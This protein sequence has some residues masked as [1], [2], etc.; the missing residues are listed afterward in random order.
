MPLP[1][2]TTASQNLPN[3]DWANFGSPHS[4]HKTLPASKNATQ[5]LPSH[6]WAN[7]GSHRPALSTVPRPSNDNATANDERTTRKF[8]FAEPPAA[9]K[10][11]TNNFGIQDKTPVSIF[12]LPFGEPTQHSKGE[13][14]IS[15]PA[16][17]IAFIGDHRFPP[18]RPPST[19]GRDHQ[20]CSLSFAEAITTALAMQTPKIDATASVAFQPTSLDCFKETDAPVRS[21]EIKFQTVDTAQVRKMRR[22]TRRLRWAA[23]APARKVNREPIA[24]RPAS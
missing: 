9:V 3:H 15:S 1:A 21:C 6:D 2:S 17:T 4:V 23:P 16:R 8:S 20:V 12:S 10:Q 5:N 13:S 18:P 22:R 14:H 7:F 11:L 24:P 19:N